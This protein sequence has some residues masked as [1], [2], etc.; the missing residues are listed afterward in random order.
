MEKT[1]SRL[2]REALEATQEYQQL[3]HKQQLF[4]MTYCMGGL[5]DGFY[6]QVS[7]T[8]TAYNC[9]NIESAR[10]M[11]YSI[12]A[13]IKIVA[14]LNR[15]FNRE[16]IESFLIQVDRAIANKKLSQAQIN[17]LKL[18]ADILGYPARLPG[19]V[20]NPRGV[21]PADVLEASEAARKA[22]RKPREAK[23][24]PEKPSDY[25]FGV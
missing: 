5:T 8:L 13:N 12:I 2:G 17:A 7:A 23:P 11:S 14:A 3:T 1:T 22:K 24:Q 21:L 20:G 16:P 15:H 18:K 9:K 25:G 10:V 6:D 4:V 19:T